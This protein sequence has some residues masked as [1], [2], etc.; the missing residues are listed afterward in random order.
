MLL[1]SAPTRSASGRRKSAAGGL[2]QPLPGASHDEVAA[3][4]EVVSRMQ[5]GTW[6]GV[7]KKSGRFATCTFNHF[8]QP[9]PVHPVE[10]DTAPPRPMAPSPMMVLCAQFL[11]GRQSAKRFAMTAWKQCQ[12]VAHCNALFG[13]GTQL[14]YVANSGPGHDEPQSLNS[15]IYTL[16]RGKIRV[17]E[18]VCEYGTQVFRRYADLWM[19]GSI[20]TGN[21]CKAAIAFMASP[22]DWEGKTPRRGRR[23]RQSAARTWLDDLIASRV[24]VVPQVALDK[25]SGVRADFGTHTSYVTTISED[26]SCHLF[27]QR[28]NPDTQ[29]REVNATTEGTKKVAN[30]RCAVGSYNGL[31]TTATPGC[32][33]NRRRW[34]LRKPERQ[35]R[36][37]RRLGCRRWQSHWQ[38]AP[39]PPQA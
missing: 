22:V 12:H 32:A 9:Q 5:F 6:F 16:F 28:W 26:G 14:W 10:A 3:D 23:R 11:C 27:E 34:R 17:M 21:M 18:P 30:T 19:A 24:Y 36:S 20:S 38:E 33:A 25:G 2:S 35:L 29:R 4:D 1:D 15:G 39:P 37:W 7:S 31:T 13:D 8:A